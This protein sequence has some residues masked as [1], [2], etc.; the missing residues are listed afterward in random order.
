MAK[1]ACTN[2]LRG[3]VFIASLA[4]SLISSAASAETTD[5]A[6]VNISTPDVIINT[7]DAIVNEDSDSGYSTDE[8]KRA[9]IAQAKKKT[10]KAKSKKKAKAPPIVEPARPSKD[11]VVAQPANT[12]KPADSPKSA[13]ADKK[14]I[15]TAQ[16]M[17]ATKTS[18]TTTPA[19]STPKRTAKRT[20]K[21]AG[22]SKEAGTPDTAAPN[23]DTLK[24]G[25]EGIFDA[26]IAGHLHAPKDLA[27]QKLNFQF[28]QNATYGSDWKGALGFSAWDETSFA[29]VSERYSGSVIRDDSRDLRLRNAYVQYHSDGFFLRVGNQQVVW[30]E[31]FGFFYSDIVNPK[32]YRYG[33]FGDFSQI[34]LQTPMVNAKLTFSELSLQAIFIPKPY[35]NILPSPGNDFAFP[36]QSSF[37]VSNFS[38]QR[39]TTLP[40]S[41]NHMEAGARV[42]YLLNRL[43]LSVFF[44]NYM[45][46]DPWYTI[47]A[48]S[49][50]PTN[51]VL[52]EHH[53][54]VQSFGL[55][56][57]DEIES[58][59]F[60]VEALKTQNRT[61]PVVVNTPFGTGLSTSQLDNYIY[62]IGMDVP[63]MDKWNLG[64][65]WS[66]D[67]LSKN[68]PGLLRQQ[69]V[70]LASLR[71][72]APLF[73]NH[74]AEFLYTY[75]VGDAGQR[76]EFN[77]LIP[78][79]G[80]IETTLGIDV[81]GGPQTSA[82]G[83]IYQATR[84][85]VLF[86]YFLK[87]RG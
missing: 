59:V 80:T 65:Q 37:G 66:Q 9:E 82:F 6:D 41:S 14:A 36:Y 76:A 67:I 10:K 20:S 50:L 62:V 72:Q 60:R 86:K 44:F 32:D 53:S 25:Y 24:Y 12:D 28:E 40:I 78:L 57:T 8:F 27:S 43:D 81:L 38:I 35:F 54:R 3:A 13:E 33:L 49:Q 39:E 5:S 48:D 70:S 15:D 26:I 4:S 16:S 7:P 68:E 29:T 84:A 46:R 55:T 85:Y 22:A 83:S 73:K 42:S 69:T 31:A 64:F 11:P 63:P 18:D 61:L 21:K 74:S 45:D 47:S 17:D 34:R 56:A 79:S 77:Y 51:L 71:L 19:V 58:F 1:S 30:G 87:V 2:V 75:S 23:L 52:Q